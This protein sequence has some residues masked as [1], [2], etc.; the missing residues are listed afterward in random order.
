MTYD[1]TPEEIQNRLR[2]ESQRPGRFAPEGELPPN[3]ERATPIQQQQQPPPPPEPQRRRRRGGQRVASVYFLDAEHA[4]AVGSAGSI[5][6]SQN[7]GKTWERQ[8]GEQERNELPRGA[9]LR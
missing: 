9:F 4:W 5:Y 2:S 6:Y 8:L 7:G 3:A 1:E